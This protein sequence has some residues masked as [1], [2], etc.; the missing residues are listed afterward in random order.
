MKTFVTNAGHFPADSA[1]TSFIPPTTRASHGATLMGFPTP[2][3]FAY[4]FAAH[5]LPAAAGL[6]RRQCA[7]LGAGST[8]E[9]S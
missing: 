7:F 1:A 3:G 8:L 2:T 5:H 9:S 6:Y 4:R